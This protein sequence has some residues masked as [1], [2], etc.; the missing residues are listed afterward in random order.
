MRCIGIDAVRACAVQIGALRRPI[1]LADFVETADTAAACGTGTLGT[2]WAETLE[3]SGA[4]EIRLIGGE[5]GG[6]TDGLRIAGAKFGIVVIAET[7][8]E[9][10]ME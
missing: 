8:C 2:V 7:L 4:A 10:P 3:A 5:V 1:M 9:G 6:W